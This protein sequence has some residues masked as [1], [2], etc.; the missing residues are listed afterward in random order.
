MLT[1]W[2]LALTSVL[3]S[4]LT[5]RLPVIL[6]AWLWINLTFSF[7]HWLRAS[8]FWM[9]KKSKDRN[10]EVYER[11]DTPIW[12]Y[13]YDRATRKMNWETKYAEKRENA[14]RE[15]YYRKYKKY[16]NKTLTIQH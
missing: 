12:W 3:G 11:V 1:S 6:T 16:P 9:L 10:V 13:L 4:S 7:F 8:M 15:E 2:L 14:E 5:L